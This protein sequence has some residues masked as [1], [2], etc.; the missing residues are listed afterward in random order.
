MSR[1][2]PKKFVA[3]VISRP[4]HAQPA[5]SPGKCGRSARAESDRRVNNA[6]LQTTA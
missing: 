4:C 5:S 1:K 2:G 6:Q 3:T